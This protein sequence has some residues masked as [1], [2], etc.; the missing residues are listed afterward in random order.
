L[1]ACK[2]NFDGVVGF[3]TTVGTVDS[4][5]RCLEFLNNWARSISVANF[6]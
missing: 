5:S 6:L 3:V 4:I 1:V 2:C